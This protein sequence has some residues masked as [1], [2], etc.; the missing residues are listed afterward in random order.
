MIYD[1][2]LGKVGQPLLVSYRAYEGFAHL[3]WVLAYMAHWAFDNFEIPNG[4]FLLNVL[5]LPLP[6]TSFT[7][8]LAFYHVLHVRVSLIF[9]L[10]VFFTLC[11]LRLPAFLKR[12]SVDRRH[13]GYKSTS[14]HAALR[15]HLPVS[16]RARI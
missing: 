16:A 5:H 10:D 1:G 2:I 9:L 4:L 12:R 15:L 3:A 6:S 7:T 14:S 13:I 8:W 11:T